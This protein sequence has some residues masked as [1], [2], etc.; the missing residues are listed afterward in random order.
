[1]SSVSGVV[2]TIK[3]ALIIIRHITINT[4]I[5]IIVYMK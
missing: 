2:I 4:Y 3:Q 5:P 1:M